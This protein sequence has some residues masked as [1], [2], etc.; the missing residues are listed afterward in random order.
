MLLYRSILN[1]L[2]QLDIVLADIDGL[3]SLV[4]SDRESQSNGITLG[5]LPNHLTGDVEG[6]ERAV[7]VAGTAV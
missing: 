3:F 2:F 5:R 7:E 1:G 4:A 6:V